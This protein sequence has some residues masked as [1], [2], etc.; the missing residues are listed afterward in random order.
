MGKRYIL[1]G[2]LVVL[3]IVALVTVAYALIPAADGVLAAGTVVEVVPLPG[4][5]RD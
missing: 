4:A 3:L 5:G 1:A 2:L